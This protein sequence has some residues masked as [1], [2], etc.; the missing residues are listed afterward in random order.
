MVHVMNNP[1]L[2]LLLVAFPIG[3]SIQILSERLLLKRYPR[4]AWGGLFTAGWAVGLLIVVI[5]FPLGIILYANRIS[6][7]FLFYGIPTII[8]A[9]I[10]LNLINIMLPEA[11]DD[12]PPGFL[13]DNFN[14]EYRRVY[15][16]C[17]GLTVISFILGLTA[18][19]DPFFSV[20]QMSRMIWTVAFTVG[21]LVA[22]KRPVIHKA[23][24]WVALPLTVIF[25][26]IFASG[27]VI[28]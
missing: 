27:S 11:P 19:Q 5:Q 17:L 25:F 1:A 7:S 14:R 6:S 15:W 9:Y 12:V 18:F 20:Q 23:I 13:L 28:Q 10:M 4:K 16:C 3:R 22:P 26:I 2:L 24:W 21:L 8:Y